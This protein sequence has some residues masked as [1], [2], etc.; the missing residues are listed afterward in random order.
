MGQQVLG[1]AGGHRFLD[2]GGLPGI[3]CRYVALINFGI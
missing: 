3:I 2:S 1:S